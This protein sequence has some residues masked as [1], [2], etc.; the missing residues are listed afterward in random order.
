MKARDRNC[1]YYSY[2]CETSDEEFNEELSEI[3][4]DKRG[5]EM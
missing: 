3:V 2:S 5:V 1:I 4:R